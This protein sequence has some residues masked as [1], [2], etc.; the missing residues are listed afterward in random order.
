M[1]LTSLQSS[2]FSG[3][4]CL[5]AMQAH[6][7]L[8]TLAASCGSIAC[9]PSGPAPRAL[10][11][12]ARDALLTHGLSFLRARADSMWPAASGGKVFLGAVRA[13]G[14]YQ[15]HPQAWL[16]AVAPSTDGLC[17][18]PE[19]PCF[20]GHSG[21]LLVLGYPRSH[22]GDSVSLEVGIRTFEPHPADPRSEMSGGFRP[23]EALTR[24]TSTYTWMI[25][26]LVDSSGTVRVVGNT[27]PTRTVVCTRC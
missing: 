15:Q 14:P 26:A 6:A 20:H 1:N 27:G 22:P 7:L 4:R 3:N 2:V 23:T 9:A 17:Y 25:A 21:R 12:P 13:D 8:F 24:W 5:I 18:P 10:G 19:G 16:A 11:A